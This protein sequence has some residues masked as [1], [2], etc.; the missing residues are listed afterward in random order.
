MHIELISKERIARYVSEAARQADY[1]Q[2][3]G[4]VG[5]DLSQ[6]HYWAAYTRQSTREQSENDRLGEYLLT[7]AKLAKHYGV[8]VPIEYIIYDAQSSEDLN[9]PGMEWLRRDLIPQRKISG[10]VIPFQGRL[11]AD[12]LHQLTLERECEHHQVKLVCGDAPTGNDWG[13]RTTRLIQAQA[14][15]LR[16]KSNR[17]NV[18]A[19]N[20]ARVMMGKVP[21]Q[22]PPYG[23]VMV[24]DKVIDSRSGRVRVNSARWE[25]DK[26]DANGEFEVQS[27]AWV[28]Q[29]IFIWIAE[30]ERTCY[31]VASELN[32][33]KIPP[34]RRDVWSPKNVIAMIERKSYTGHAEYNMFGRYPNPDHPMG[35]PTMGEKRTLSL[36]KPESE[37][38]KFEVPPITSDYL[39]RLANKV[40]K[41]RGR[42]RGKQGK[43]IPALFRN[44]LICPMCN[45]PMGVMR[46]AATGD[47]FYYCR[48][49]YYPWIKDHCTYR[50]FIPA[51]WDDAI[52][53]ELCH[54][55]RD[56]RWVDVQLQE[57]QAH[58][59]DKGKL[60][61]MEESKVRESTQ[62]IIRIQEGWE[63]GI[64][65]QE[66]AAIRIGELRK[67]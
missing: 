7:C 67:K 39:W 62:K 37:R 47:I 59:Q 32:K 66:E 43:V 51:T 11:S 16:V 35:D 23:Y 44:R 10:I 24:A 33:L 48:P 5:C 40:I 28:V 45:K 1:L 64:Y 36:P 60:V 55:L 6:K 42:G 27:P 38:V 49:H 50:K 9:R 8:V 56:D 53:A 4:V 34:P 18:V 19:G 54:L 58:L 31:W 14:N 13:S 30:R 20:K 65:T 15:S 25:I 61:K 12:P 17:D 57:E 22:H 52:W 63:K 21:P 29:N 2:G 3:F 41:D 46:K 26:V